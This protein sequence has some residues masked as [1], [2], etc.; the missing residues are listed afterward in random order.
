MCCLWCN[1]CDCEG[2]NVHMYGMYGLLYVRIYINICVVCVCI[3]IMYVGYTIFCA[4]KWCTNVYRCD[5]LWIKC[6]CLH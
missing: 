1:V 4:C 2:T 5:M 6:L 3:C